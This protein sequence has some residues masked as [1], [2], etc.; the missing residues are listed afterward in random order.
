MPAKSYVSPLQYDKMTP[1]ELQQAELHGF[2]A[3]DR[4]MKS[5]APQRPARQTGAY[6]R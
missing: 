3:L 6:F 4:A 1:E 5:E 2:A